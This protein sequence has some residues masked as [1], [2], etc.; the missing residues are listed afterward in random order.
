METRANFVAI[1]FFTLLLTAIGFGFV[2]WI[3]RYDDNRPMREVVVQFHGTVAGLT[4]GGLVMFNGIKVGEVSQLNYDP[5]HPQF[6]KAKLL[7]DA[8]I[9]LKQDTNVELAF[10]GLTGVG[11]VEMK[12]GDPKLPNLFASEDVPQMMAAHSAFE[13]LMSGA[14]LIL[15]RSEKVLQKVESI[16]VTNEGK[17]NNAI[18]NVESFTK[19]LDNNSENIDTFLADASSAA[20]GLTSLSAKL[21]TLSTKAETLIGAVEPDSVRKSVKNV[22]TFSTKLAEASEKFDTVV[23]DASEAAKGINSFSANLNTSLGKVDELVAAVD[24]EK[25]RAAITSLTTFA[26]SL[27]TSSGDI[28]AIL[29][30]AKQAAKNINQFSQTMSG[31]SED[32]N[33]IITDARDIASRLSKASKRVDGLLGKVDGVLSD[34]EGGKGLITEATLAARSIRKVSEKFEARADEIANGLSRFSGKGLRDV[35]AMVGDARRTLR[36]L[37]GAV[38]KLESN[39]SSLL[40]GGNKVKTYNRRH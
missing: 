18:S 4:T 32:F 34:D 40:F 8:E 27:D 19:A 7:V 2:Y 26:T 17:I 15:K 33:Q 38:E 12:G 39:P 10:Q 1:G 31:R 29:G 6:V 5:N 14:R 20:K 21:E 11:Y 25:V 36:R 23:A 35:E 13:D 28:S 22:E 3:A 37:E 24:P 30:E 16:V 9:P